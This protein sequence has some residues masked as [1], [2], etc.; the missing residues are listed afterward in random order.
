MQDPRHARRWP[1]SVPRGIRGSNRV[2]K[3]AYLTF[4]G[5]SWPMGRELLEEEAIKLLR[6]HIIPVVFGQEHKL[7]HNWLGECAT[8]QLAK[9]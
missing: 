2:K 3:F 4:N 9:G 7:D 8:A 6:Q 1:C 5:N